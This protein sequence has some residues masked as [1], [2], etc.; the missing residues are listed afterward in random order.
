MND[1]DFMIYHDHSEERLVEPA[2]APA[3]QEPA[4]EHEAEKN[5]TTEKTA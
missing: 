5:G 1:D 2:P 4:L 3:A